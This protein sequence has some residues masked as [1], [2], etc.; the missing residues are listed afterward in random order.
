MIRGGLAIAMSESSSIVWAT[1]AVISDDYFCA[2]C[3][4][5]MILNSMD[6]SFQ[7]PDSFNCSAILAVQK[8][9]LIYMHDLLAGDDSSP[10]QVR[11]RCDNCERPVLIDLNEESCRCSLLQAEDGK[12]AL[13]V[14][15][16]AL[17]AV[18]LMRPASPFLCQQAHSLGACWLEIDAR[19][20]FTSSVVD[21]LT[22]TLPPRQ[23]DLCDDQQAQMRDQVSATAARHG[24]EFDTT[25]YRARLHN[26]SNCQERI[27]Y[28]RWNRRQTWATEQPPKPVPLSIQWR[29]SHVRNAYCWINT[30]PVCGEMQDEEESGDDFAAWWSTPQF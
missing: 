10:V 6:H 28:F 17:R 2:H 9:A 19:N 13:L 27:L 30:C 8:A 3:G 18:I 20:L 24:T 4:A 29:W 15:S 26:C 12:E 16:S 7:H 1:E 11:T 21:V 22:G 23:C 14:E 5:T 25:K